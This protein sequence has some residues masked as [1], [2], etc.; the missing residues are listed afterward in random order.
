MRLARGRLIGVRGVL[1]LKIEW[2]GFLELLGSV[3]KFIFRYSCFFGDSLGC[4]FACSLA[5]GMDHGIK[6]VFPL[7]MSCSLIA[8]ADFSERGHY[9]ANFLNAV[10]GNLP[11]GHSVDMGCLKGIVIET[12]SELS[13]PS[14]RLILPDFVEKSL[15]FNTYFFC[16]LLERLTTDR[17]ILAQAIYDSPVKFSHHISF[18]LL[19]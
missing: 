8:M 12:G 1:L 16:N 19:G 3:E 4:S 11:Y 13:D 10:M 15:L 6:V 14:L 5:L 18:P 2:G 9:L 7:W 17:Q